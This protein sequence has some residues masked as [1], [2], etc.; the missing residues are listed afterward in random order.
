MSEAV[1]E[2]RAHFS[3]HALQ[4]MQELGRVI[5]AETYGEDGPLIKLSTD[6]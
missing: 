6:S 2:R 1:E 3:P 4:L 5:S